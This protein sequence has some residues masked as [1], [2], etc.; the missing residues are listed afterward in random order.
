[1]KI[2]VP[3]ILPT[4]DFKK[5]ESKELTVS[6]NIPDSMTVNGNIE[7][8]VAIPDFMFNELANS[9]PQFKTEY[10]VNNFNVSGLFS[11][12][13]LT[14]KFKK[15]QTSVLI[16]ELQDYIFSLT[17]FL[18]E[19][20]SIET[21]TMKKKIFISFEHSEKYT[22]NEWNGAYMGKYIYQGFKYFVGYE[23]LTDKYYGGDLKP[24]IQKRYIS[25]IFYASPNSSL[26]KMDTG[27]KEKTDI[28]LDLLNSKQ[29]IESFE[30]EYSIVDWSEERE[31]FCEK[32]QNTF[33][34]VNEELD[35]FLK[36]IDDN[37][38]NEL[39]SNG[40]KFLGE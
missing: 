35:S 37:K 8:S 5:A 36:D 18:N 40:L 17:Q 7:Y 27:F 39:I 19:K 33:I 28:F 3:F 9:E 11:E 25:K 38:M 13:S 29:S 14:R 20:Y 31:K 4:S 23:V 21:E 15:T 1:M 34:Q 30:N 26:S 12:R 32:I 6:M 10:D 2:K 24:K 16:K 22:R